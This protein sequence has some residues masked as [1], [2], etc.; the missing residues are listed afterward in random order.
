MVNEKMVQKSY[1]GKEKIPI[2][3]ESMIETV[4]PYLL[5]YGPVSVSFIIDK[6]YKKELKNMK[7]SGL[8]IELCMNIKTSGEPYYRHGYLVGIKKIK[9]HNDKTI[10]VMGELQR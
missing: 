5:E 2:E 8:S 4:T 9:K 3:V 6:K 7:K 1:L 10:E